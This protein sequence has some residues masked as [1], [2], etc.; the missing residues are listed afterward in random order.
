MDGTGPLEDFQTFVFNPEFTNL[1]RLVPV[2]VGFMMDNLV[3]SPSGEETPLPPPPPLPLLYDITWDASPHQLG[4]VT[5][6]GGPYG[7]HPRVH[8]GL[9]RLSTRPG[10]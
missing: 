1:D 5:A 9:P 10:Q 6:V 2:E 3:V 4:E 8:L 7:R